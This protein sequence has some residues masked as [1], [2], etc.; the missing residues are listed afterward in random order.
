MRAPVIAMVLS[1]IGG[2]VC[3]QPANQGPT[4]LESCFE[5]ARAADA[6]CSN[7]ANDA[8]QRLDCLQKARTAQLQCLEKVAPESSAGSTPSGKA[9]GSGASEATSGAASSQSPAAAAA[10]ALPAPT[11]S[12]DQP[13][14]AVLPD[15][16]TASVPPD[17]PAATVSPELASGSVAPDKATATVPPELP[18][19]AVSPDKATATVPPELPSA[20]VT[21][22]KAAATLPPELPSATVTPDKTTAIVPP[23]LPTGT[24]L[25]DR[26]T[27]AV[28]PN[29][30]G[31]DVAVPP[32]PRGTNWVVS[33]TTSPVDYSPLISAAIRLPLG[34][35]QAPNTLAL[36]CR[37]GRTELLVRA[38]GTWRASRTGDV[39][40]D[41]QID[42][43]PLVRLPWAISADGM[44]ATYKNDAVGFL[45]SLPEGARLRISVLDGPGQSHEAI[46]P[47]A[48]LD[49][50]RGKIAAACKWAPAAEKTS[51]QK[52]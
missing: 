37:G 17:K 19:G 40:V 35:K 46:F 7:P 10:A 5:S 20:T 47:L 4:G 24:V 51:S 31:T 52:R 30:P 39:Q 36:R 48:G 3:A 9:V 43:Q 38:E 50:V 41:T 42:D 29:L 33:E 11:A 23:D 49:A 28:A 8:L 14:A 25:P 26:P 22:D 12:P 1:G 45:Q 6:I 15:K 18:S 34:V 16:P 13:T 2:A 27:V 21:P 44:T 32:K